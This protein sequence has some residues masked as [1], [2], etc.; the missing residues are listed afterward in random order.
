[1]SVLI[2]RIKTVENTARNLGKLVAGANCF[3]LDLSTLIVA[4]S[5]KWLWYCLSKSIAVSKVK[6]KDISCIS[7]HGN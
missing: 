3:M 7:S 6:I 4:I 1:M 2:S 5:L